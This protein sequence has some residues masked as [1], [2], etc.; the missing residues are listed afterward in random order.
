MEQR[1][2]TVVCN[3]LNRYCRESFGAIQLFCVLLFSFIVLA[4]F[5]TCG[6][7]VAASEPPEVASTSAIL[8]DATT[9]RVL[10][11]KDDHESRPMASTTKIMTALVTLERCSPDE[12]TTV[13]KHATEVR[14]SILGLKEGERIC[15][16]DLLEAMLVKSANDA[17][18]ALAEHVAGSEQAFVEL[19]NE[20]A[21]SL[22]CTETHFTNPH[23]LY[24]PDHHSSAADLSLIAQQAMRLPLFRKLVA[25]ESC[26]MER[27]DG[28]RLEICNHN[29]LLSKYDYADGI[30]T[31]FVRQSG[32]CLVASA[33]RNGW[34]LIAVLLNSGDLWNDAQSLLEYGF[35]NW[36]GKAIAQAQKPFK[37][38]R[39]YGGQKGYVRAIA[40]SD[41]VALCQSGGSPKTEV[42]VDL[43][44]LYAPVRRGQRIGQV[45]LYEGDRKI[46]ST[47][48]LASSAVDRTL[49]FA[50]MIGF[51]KFL[52]GLMGLV[53]C[54]K[55]YVKITK[56]A[57]RRRYRFQ[58]QG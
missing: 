5:P 44:R 31:G 56:A 17:A 15:V 37:T 51:G 40:T 3:P 19:M 54:I 33:S 7:S 6:M 45:T 58:T 22:G 46:G 9:G 35:K 10:Y 4:A 49:W 1:F 21:K 50:A 39:V 18:I 26:F 25:T 47:Q 23:G 48:L 16:G 13:S 8:I 57:R 27:P 12:I 29:R 41:L 43:D 28:T 42:K 36:Q 2:N 14:P 24:D 20:R 38:V 53:G 11:E 34:R 32:R 52:L 30:K 55:V